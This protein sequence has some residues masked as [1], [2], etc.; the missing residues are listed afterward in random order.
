MRGD[1]DTEFDN[2]AVIL[3]TIYNFYEAST[4]PY[5]E[6]TAVLRCAFTPANKLFGLQF[7]EIQDA[8]KWHE[9]QKVYQVLEE[10]RTHIGVIYMDFFTRE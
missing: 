1:N 5:F 2:K 10:D 4:R 6:F 8:P 7:I 9:D 3:R